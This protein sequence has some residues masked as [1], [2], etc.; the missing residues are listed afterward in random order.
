MSCKYCFNAIVYAREDHPEEE[1]FD[2]YFDSSNDFSSCGIGKADGEHMIYFN[3]GAG[4]PCNIEIMNLAED[5]QWHTV[6][7]YFPKFCPECGR[8]LNE[9][10]EKKVN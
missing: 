2:T 1:Y 7:R 10:N 8:E 9:Y 6:G 3:S 4:H 5:N